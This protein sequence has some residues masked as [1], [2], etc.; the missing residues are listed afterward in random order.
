MWALLTAGAIGLLAFG[1]RG[2]CE[3]FGLLGRGASAK[4]DTQ[5]ASLDWDDDL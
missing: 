2:L 1:F 5:D 3:Q 4:N